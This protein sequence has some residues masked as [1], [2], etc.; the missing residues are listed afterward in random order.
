MKGEKGEGGG[1]NWDAEWKK[2]KARLPEVPVEN[3]S[4]RRSTPR[5]RVGRDSIRDQ[6][7]AVLDIFSQESFFKVGGAVVVFLVLF[8]VFVIGPPE[9]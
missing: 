8:F 6:E 5:S 4:S 2:A 1:I 7:N 9:G 3:V